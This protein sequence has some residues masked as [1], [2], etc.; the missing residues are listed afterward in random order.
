MECDQPKLPYRPDRPSVGV[1]QK[2]HSTRKA[3]WQTTHS[4]HEKGY[5][6]HSVYCGWWVSVEDDAHTVSQVEERVP[7]LQNVA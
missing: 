1:Y 6:R 2:V 4:G 3:W 7:L 5:Q